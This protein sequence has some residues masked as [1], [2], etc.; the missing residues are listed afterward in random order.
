MTLVIVYDACHDGL[1]IAKKQLH[2]QSLTPSP[3]TTHAK[4]GEKTKW[5]MSY[6]QP[7]KVK[8]T[9]T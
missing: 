7:E 8:T 2:T 5:A 1:S 4:R 6:Y 9:A 3:V